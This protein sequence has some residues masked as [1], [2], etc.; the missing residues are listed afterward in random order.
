MN[1]VYFMAVGENYLAHYGVKGMKWGQRRA[2][3]KDARAKKWAKKK[4]AKGRAL[5]VS[6][7]E[8]GDHI[9]QY[10]YNYETRRDRKLAKKTSAKARYYNEELKKRRA[11]Q[12]REF[13]AFANG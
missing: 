8:N 10:D 13:E 11:N 4:V 3:R 9:I 6:Q 2:A 1:E 5:L 7:K 12:K